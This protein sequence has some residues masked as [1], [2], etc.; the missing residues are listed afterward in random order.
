[1]GRTNILSMLEPGQD[2]ELAGGS[3]DVQLLFS[4]ERLGLLTFVLLHTI[5]KVLSRW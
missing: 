1:V 3:L 5:D 4:T 2:F